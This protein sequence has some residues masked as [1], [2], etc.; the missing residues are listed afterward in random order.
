MD[1]AIYIWSNLPNKVTEILPIKLLMKSQVGDY[2]H[3]QTL[4][5]FGCPCYM[6]DSK[7]QYGKTLPKKRVPQ[8]CWGHYQ[9][10]SSNNNA[11]SIGQIHNVQMGHIS[12]QF[13]VV[14]DELFT[15]VPNVDDPTVPNLEEVD[16][17]TLLRAHG[18]RDYY[19]NEDIDDYGNLILPPE[20]SNSAQK[21][22]H[23]WQP[24]FQPLCGIQNPG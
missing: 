11:S 23:H 19:V 21:D 2:S 1:Q 12:P 14:Y 4:H 18:V 15:T 6:L 24:K 16:L 8:T 7:L 13:H 20:L 9:G 10:V 5:V 22:L 17:D 3:L